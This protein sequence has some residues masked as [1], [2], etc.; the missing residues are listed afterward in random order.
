MQCKRDD[1]VNAKG[2]G[3]LITYVPNLGGQLSS[4]YIFLQQFFALLLLLMDNNK[5]S[6]ECLDLKASCRGGP[7]RYGTIAASNCVL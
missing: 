3:G 4:Y 7:C 2:K 1:P 5:A 6:Q